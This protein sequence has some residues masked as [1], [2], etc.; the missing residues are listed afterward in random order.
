MGQN[1]KI[2]RENFSKREEEKANRVFK[3]ICAFLVLLGIIITIGF[4]LM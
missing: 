2:K 4:A 3:M 1:R